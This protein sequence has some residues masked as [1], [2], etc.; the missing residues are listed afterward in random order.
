LNFRSALNTIITC[1]GLWN[2]KTMFTTIICRSSSEKHW[3]EFNHTWQRCSL[4]CPTQVLLLSCRFVKKM[5]K[6]RMC[7][8]T[9]SSPL[10]AKCAYLPSHIWD[11][12]AIEPDLHIM[13]VI[14]VLKF[15]SPLQV[16]MVFNADRKF[17]MVDSEG[18]N[19]FENLW[20]TFS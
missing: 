7:P 20:I 5:N 19:C 18:Q 13:V 2:F 15:Q 10:S 11:L 9:R 16:I 1:K 8:R 3:T 14:I 12:A 17:K 6:R 4:L